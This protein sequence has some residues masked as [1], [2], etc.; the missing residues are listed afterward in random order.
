MGVDEIIVAEASSVGI[1]IVDQGFVSAKMNAVVESASQKASCL[2][3]IQSLNL[4]DDDNKV[5]NLVAVADVPMS[6]DQDTLEI[7]SLDQTED[8]LISGCQTPTGNIFDPFA[9]GPEELM[10]CAPKKKLLKEVRAPLRRQLNFDS[11]IDSDDAAEEELLLDS[12]YRSFLEVIVANQVKEIYGEDLIVEP[13]LE[14]HQME[15]FQT[16]TSLPLLTGIAE[17]CPPAPVRPV[18]KTRKISLDICKKLEF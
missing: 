1:G 8:D 2:E 4:N 9:L 12:V 6:P 5:E 13:H 14:G 11:C 7:S 3:K 10:C 18:L 15:G 16:P 17:T